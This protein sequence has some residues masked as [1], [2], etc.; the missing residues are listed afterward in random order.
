MEEGEIAIQIK[1]WK[2]H[3]DAFWELK[4]RLTEGDDSEKA[5][6]AAKKAKS[7][8]NKKL[9]KKELE[10]LK[11]QEDAISASTNIK[12]DPFFSYFNLGSVI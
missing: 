6:A 3:C 10:A 9:S 11:E 7:N 5:A 2:K 12:H 1:D 8:K 4:K